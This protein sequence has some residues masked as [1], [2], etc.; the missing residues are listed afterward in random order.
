MSVS[1]VNKLWWRAAGTLSFRCRSAAVTLAAISALAAGENLYS[2]SWESVELPVK[3]NVGYAV[4]ALD[5]NQDDKLDIAIV[6]SKRV[7]WLENPTWREHVIYATPDAKSDNVCFAPHD[8]DGDGLID[9]ALGADWQPNN[10]DSGGS[11]GWLQQKPAGTWTYFPLT[12]VPTTHRMQWM[13]LVNG[14]KSLV[15]APLKGKGSRAP[16]WDQTAVQL[17]ALTPPKRG[18]AAPWDSRTLCDQLHVIHNFHIADLDDDQRADL[19]CA[20]YEGATWL[21]FDKEANLSQAARLGAGQEQTPPAK[22]ASEIRCGRLAGGRQY[23]ATIEPWH[24]D[25][26]VVYIAPEQWKADKAQ[27]LW[28]RLV[29]DEQL[30]WGHAVACANL[31]DDPEDELI[32]GVRDNQSEEH[33]SG[34]RI[35]NPDDASGQSWTRTLLDPGAV[36]V[37]DLIAADINR[38]GQTDIIAVGRATHNAKLYLNRRP[39]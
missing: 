32:I 6:D 22:G 31:D 24:G 15:V 12:N 27:T 10:T 39:Q 33:R 36:A 20:S 23:V 35:Y 4:R 26:V 30:A 3:L 21:R 14:A 16:G 5:M 25:K 19:L 37:E 9:V 34:V 17:L 29:I 1:S 11:I 28:Q 8:V 7:L 13:E 38:D 18:G 2:Q